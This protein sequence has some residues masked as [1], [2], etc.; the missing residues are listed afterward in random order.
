M[1]V[2]QVID[3]R[4]RRQIAREPNEIVVLKSEVLA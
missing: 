4:N 3:G 1:R 2:L